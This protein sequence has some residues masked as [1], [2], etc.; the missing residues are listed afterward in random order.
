MDMNDQEIQKLIQE[1][2]YH[3]NGEI[4]YSEFLYATIDTKK[5]LTDQ[6]LRAIFNQFDTDKTDK[7]T[8]DNIRVA[9]QK[10]GQEHSMEELREMIKKHD[11]TGDNALSFEEF[12]AIFFGTKD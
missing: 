10:L 2:D 5:F 3:G 9:F 4:N 7:I 6:R 12:K 8:A 11:I 1:I